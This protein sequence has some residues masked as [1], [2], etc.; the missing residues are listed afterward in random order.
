MIRVKAK[1]HTQ[2]GF[3]F[4]EISGHAQYAEYGKDIV[5]A[6]VSALAETAVLGLEQVAHI[7]PIVKK[8]EGYFLLKLPD[9]VQ[10]D[11]LTKAAVILDTVFLGLADISKSYPT[12][13]R[14]ELIGE[15]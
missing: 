7:K 14:I 10:M 15:V 5:C 11:A 3:E 6:G 4:L 13:V 8:R 9:D 1:R 2:G 12:N